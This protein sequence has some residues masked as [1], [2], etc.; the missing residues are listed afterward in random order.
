MTEPEYQ[1]TTAADWEAR[2]LCPDEGCIGV[3]GTDGRCKVCGKL[4]SAPPPTPAPAGE[5]GS[6]EEKRSEAPPTLSEGSEPT[7]A[8]PQPEDDGV[9]DDRELCPDEACIGLLGPDGACKVCG[10]RRAEE[11]GRGLS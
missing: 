11:T 6:A 4:G 10:K 7:G 9:S 8:A 3:I 1:E 5:G 2:A